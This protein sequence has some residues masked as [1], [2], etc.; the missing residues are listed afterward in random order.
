MQTERACWAAGPVGIQ[1]GRR[2]VGVREDER[3]VHTL[4]PSPRGQ[5][6]L[7]GLPGLSAHC[8]AQHREFT[9]YFMEL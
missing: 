5:S 1:L 8:R 2:S 9:E 7:E 3:E 4:L 6:S